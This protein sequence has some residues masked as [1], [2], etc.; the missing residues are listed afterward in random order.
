MQH[1]VIQSAQPVAET[2]SSWEQT[3]VGYNFS[4]KYGYGKIDAFEI[5]SRAK[6]FNSV[7]PQNRYESHTVF[8]NQPIT[9]ANGGKAVSSVM[10]EPNVMKEANLASIEH[11]TVTFTIEHECRGEVSI[12]LT[13]PQN[14]TSR[15]IT[16]R[17]FDK[18]T[19]GF[20]NW[21]CMSV[22]HW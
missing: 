7:K 18:S 20:K 5:V 12:D 4:H 22:K 19:E 10:I 15:L 16:T 6:A 9:P 21:T 2:D 17:R 14:I 1:L 13:S 3:A 8:A 11:T